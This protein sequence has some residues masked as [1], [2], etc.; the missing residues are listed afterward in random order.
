MQLGPLLE[1]VGG[2]LDAVADWGATLSLGEQQR[3]AFARVLLARPRLVLMDESTSALD[4]RN[5]RVLYEAL[6][7]AGGRGGS[8]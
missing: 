2:N 7:A 4:T 5:E 1:R 8:G 6:K 3:L